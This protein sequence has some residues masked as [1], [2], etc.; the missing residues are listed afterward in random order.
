M[1]PVRP[2]R[3][4]VRLTEDKFASL[5]R[6]FTS[7]ANP[8]WLGYSEST[9][10]T[11]G[12]ELEFAALPET[13]GALSTQEIRPSLVQAFFDGFADRP[14]KQAVSLAA[15]RQLERWAIVRELLPRQ[16]T[17]GVEIGHSDGGHVPWTDE[18]VALAERYC[19]PM[20][21]R[22]I[23][24]AACTGQRGSDLVRMTW[25]DVEEYNGMRGINVRQKKTGRRV[26]VPILAAL[27]NAMERWERL[28]GPF[29]RNADD[30]AWTRAG[31]ARSWLHERERA[32]EL[33]EHRELGLV[34][35]GLR[36][37]ACVKLRR[38]GA[39]A[40][41]ISDMV[42]MSV[43]MVERY[44]RLSSQR[45]NAMAAVIQLE[46]TDGKHGLKK[47]PDFAS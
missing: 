47:P 26:W 40:Q 22:A 30:R 7:P 14:A 4:T 15:L 38:G 34:M 41:Q 29:L 44:C 24:L 1:Q 23:T 21:A 6:L 3:K 42:G 18:Q 28:P 45:D 16:I 17:L 2:L 33:A 31:L 39:N 19:R 27:A 5:V 32:P 46:R 10:K 20:V 43:P 11:W 12:H 8:K 13:L 25:G 9:R 36:A 37:H 35:H